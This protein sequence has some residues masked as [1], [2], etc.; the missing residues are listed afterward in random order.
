MKAVL[1]SETPENIY[2]NTRY[3]NPGDLL[4]QYKNGL[5]TNKIFQRCVISSGCSGK[6]P[7]R[8]AVPFV[9]VFFLS[10]PCQQATRSIAIIIV[11][12]LTF[13]WTLEN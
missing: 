4:P 12:L 1:S 6:Y 3:K 8:L 11:A 13:K 10:V 9:E 5:A 7:A 2:P